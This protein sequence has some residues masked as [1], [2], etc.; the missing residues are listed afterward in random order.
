MDDPKNSVNDFCDV[1]D[2]AR[3]LTKRKRTLDASFYV[4]SMPYLVKILDT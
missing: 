1:C 2:L 4:L 3:H